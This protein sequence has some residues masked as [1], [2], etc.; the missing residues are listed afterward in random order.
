MGKK[1]KKPEN[2]KLLSSVKKNHQVK[3]LYNM[4]KLSVLILDQ[5]LLSNIFDLC[6]PKAKDSEFQVHYRS[7]TFECTMKDNH[8]IVFFTIPTVFYNMPQEVTS[9]TIDYHTDDIYDAGEEVKPLSLAMAQSPEVNSILGILDAYFSKVEITEVADNSFHR[10]PSAFGFSS[11]D[12]DTDQDEPGVIFRKGPCENL[13]QTDSVI[14]LGKEAEII[15]TESR[16]VTVDKAQDGTVKA[17]YVEVPTKAFIRKT[18]DNMIRRMFDMGPDVQIKE[19]N[20]SLSKD[21]FPLLNT[22]ADKIMDV[23]PEPSIEFIDPNNIE[24]KITTRNSWYKKEKKDEKIEDGIVFGVEEIDMA[25]EMG[26]DILLSTE[27]REE[28][29]A[30]REY[31]YSGGYNGMGYM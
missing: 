13:I 21:S 3:D 14:H 15:V 16:I 5:K 29:I 6:V 7:L 31:F 27:D 24:Q 4:N 8:G 2:K 22:I 17:Q 23:L 18:K 25:N 19:M 1:E 12:Y 10:H 26:Y 28:W 9:T 11:T 30:Y 20:N